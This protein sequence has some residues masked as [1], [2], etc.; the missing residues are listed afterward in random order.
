MR[1]RPLDLLLENTAGQGSC[2]GYTFEQLA[3]MLD[4]VDANDRVGICLDT[5]HAFAAGYEINTVDGF[6]AM[7][8]ECE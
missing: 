7:R 6:A 8:S 5:C 4:G 3:F 1:S 2:L